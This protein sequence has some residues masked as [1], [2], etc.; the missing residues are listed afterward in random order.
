VELFSGGYPIH[1]PDWK[2]IIWDGANIEK[3]IVW[4][5]GMLPDTFF[6]I[7]T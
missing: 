6:T 2:P 7:A 5:G 4:Y 1:G 3:A